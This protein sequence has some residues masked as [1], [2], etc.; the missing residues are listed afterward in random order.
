MAFVSTVSPSALAPKRAYLTLIYLTL[1]GK[2]M[3]SAKTLAIII[4][5]VVKSSNDFIV[6]ILLNFQYQRNIFIKS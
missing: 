5:V 6:F 2:L 1:V 3:S 4:K